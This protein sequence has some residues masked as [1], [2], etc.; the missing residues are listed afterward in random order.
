MTDPGERTRART[1]TFDH[2]ISS[3]LTKRADTLGEILRLRLK[4]VELEADLVALDR[5]LGS[6]GYTG[7]LEAVPT[8]SAA[9]DTPFG[10]GQTMRAILDCM[11]EAGTPLTARQIAEGAARVIGQAGDDPLPIE[12][13]ARRVSKALGRLKRDGA[14]R[15]SCDALGTMHWRLTHLDAQGATGS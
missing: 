12:A 6:L 5:V 4:M 9:H 13:L 2:A 11:R 14:V 1:D 3:L 10:R 15:S 8:H 7:E